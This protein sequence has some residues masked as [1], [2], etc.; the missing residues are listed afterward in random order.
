MFATGLAAQATLVLPAS[1]TAIEG[2]TST[3]IPFGRGTPAR[4][5]C[6]Y[7]GSLFAGPTTITG[8]RFR[9][10]GG[11]T[12]AEKLV[13]CELRM[14]TTP[15]NLVGLSATFAANRGADETV[16]VPRQILTLPAQG[17]GVTPNPFLP[18]IAFATPFTYDPQNGCLALEVVVYGQPPGAYSLDATYVCDS[19]LV[20]VGPSSC[21]GSNGLALRAESAT[22]QVI[23]GRPWIAR[24]LDARP[25]DV[26]LLALGTRESGTWSGMTLPQ[27][28]SFLGATG[29]VLS[30]DTPALSWGV[31]AAD[32]SAQFPFAIPNDPLVLGYWLRFQAG[33]FDAAANPLGL[34]T[35]QAQKVQ[36]CGWEPVGRVW[37]SGTSAAFGTREIGIA[38]VVELQTQ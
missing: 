17:V 24:V 26:V 27:D 36:V 34:T 38:T 10:D 22:T 21:I 2:T 32:G 31:A 8:V 18:E 28:L 12:V 11:G 35:S 13:D 6:V 33:A 23:W 7:D 25:G 3:N 16:V 20:A 5:Q 37:S 14:S 29:C 1:H 30:I 9:L 19:P 4:V 15:N